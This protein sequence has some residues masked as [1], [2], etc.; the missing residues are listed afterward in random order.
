MARQ[1]LVFESPVELTLN[2]EMVLISNR[3]TGNNTLRSLED[4]RLVVID[5]RMVGRASR[6]EF[7]GRLC[8]DGFFRLHE[9]LFVRYCSTN[10]NA[11]RHKEKVKSFIPARC[12]DI[13]IILSSDNTEGGA[14]HSMNRKRTNNIAYGKPKDIEFF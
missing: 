4:I 8:K 11:M 13:S 2:G 1:T 12:C 9:N 10:A 7:Q 5:N 14:F 3:Q 6:T